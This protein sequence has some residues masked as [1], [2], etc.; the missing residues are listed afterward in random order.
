M[1]FNPALPSTATFDNCTLCII[2]PHAV[3][4]GLS[5]A[6]ID[7]ILEQGFEIS[8]MELFHLERQTAEEFLEVYKGV[9]TEFS[10]VVDQIISGPCIALEIRAEDAVQTFREF[11]GPSDVDIA[12]YIRPNTLR[13]RFGVN[14]IQNAVHC[15]DL[16]EDGILE[17]I[18]Q[19]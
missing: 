6:I 7:A 9:L 8:A 12:K 16:P 18:Y 1:F 5:G 4:S 10:A 11:C 17:V 14:K 15:T 13:A 19:F 3:A 2:K